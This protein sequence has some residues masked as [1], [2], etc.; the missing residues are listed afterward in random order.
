[1]QAAGLLE[2]RLRRRF[3]AAPQQVLPQAKVRMGPGDAV[4]RQ[5]QVGGRLLGGR[6]AWT[7]ERPRITQSRT[8]ST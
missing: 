3:L 6:K 8:A 5:G 1:M 4:V 2:L 7:L